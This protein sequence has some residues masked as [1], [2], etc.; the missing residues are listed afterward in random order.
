MRVR[1]AQAHLLIRTLL[2]GLWLALVMAAPCSDP[3]VAQTAGEH[4]RVLVVLSSDS[5]TATQTT[6]QRALRKTLNDGS[7]NAL[8][9]YSE[10]VGNTRAGTDYEKEFVALVQRKYEG[11]KL[12]L[13][14][15]IGQFPTRVFLRNRAELFP[16]TPIVFVAIDQ[17][18]VTDLYP[19]PGLT[20]V[21]GEIDLK[22][23]L[24]LALTLH[25]G[26][27]RVV[28]IQGTSEDDKSWAAR[29]QEDF[30]AYQSTLEFTQLTGLSTAEMQ[31][32]LSGLP[33]NT[34][35]FFV[36]NIRDNRGNTYESPDYL[37]QVSPGS[38][39]P[40]YGTTE[41]HL[42]A[43][44]VGGRLL[45]FEALGVEGA[46]VGLRVLA[47]EKPEAINPYAVPSVIMFD[48]RELQR[49][50]ISEQSLPPGSIVRFKQP[51]FWEQYKW[52][53]ISFFTAIVI[54]TLLIGWLLFTRIR[55]RQAE[56]ESLR[57][58]RVAAAEHRRLGEIVSNVPGIVW[59]S[60]IDPETKQ[61]KTTFISDHLRKMLGYTPEEWLTSPGL[62]LK[63]MPAEDREEATRVSEAVIATGKAGSTQFRWHARD[64]RTVWA[65]NYLSPIFDGGEKIVGL[66][67]VTLDITERKRSEEALRQTEEKDRAILRAIPDL[68][69]LQT[70][71]GV[72]LDYHSMNPSDLPAP[73]ELFLGKNMKEILPPDLAEDLL[74]VFERASDVGEPQSLEYELTINDQP[75]WYEARIVSSGDNILSVVRDITSRK[76]VEEALKRNEAQLTGIIESAMDAIITADENHKVLLFNSAAERIFGCTI[77]DAVGQP[78]NNF[79][80]E[81]ARLVHSEQFGAVGEGNLPESPAPMLTESTGLRRSGEQFPLEAS[82]SQIEIGGQNL[83]TVILRD[84]TERKQSLDKLRKS[85]ERF[86]KAFRANP[87][88]MSLTAASDGRYIDVNDSFLNMSGYLREELI[89]HTSLELNVWETP[90]SRARF[91][92]QLQE[93]GSVVNVETRFRTR[94]GSLRVLLSSAEQL[95]ID[96]EQCVLMASSDITERVLALQALRES[97]ERFGNM[98]ETAPVMIWI[99]D[100]A[101]NCTYVNRQWLEF[102]GRS[103]EQI[104]GNGWLAGIHPDDLERTLTIYGEAFDRRQ[105]FRVEFRMFGAD[106][107]Y[108]W[109]LSG[110]AARFSPTG[111]F[112]GYIGTALDITDRKE[113]EEAL[114]K[115]HEALMAAHQEVSRLKNQLEAENIY[116]QQ[117]LQLDQTFGEI[118]G[119]SDAI[120]YVLFK[121][122]QVAPTDATVLITGETGTGKELVARAIHSASLRKDRALI[123][124]NCAALAA[125]L[126][127][128]ELFGHEKGAFTGANA[129]KLGRF[130]LADGGTIFLDEIGELPLELQV[131]LLRVI[132]EGEFERLGGNHT[133]KVDVRI[134]AAT[135]RYLKQEVSKGAFREDL[136]YRLNVFPIT[137]PPLR[138]RKE[139]I[140]LMVEHFVNK[141]GPKFGK[142][143]T[144]VSPRTMQR[145]QSHS[146]PGNVRELVNVI[147]RATIHTQGSVL[148]LS[149]PLEDRAAPSRS[150]NLED[151]EREH[152]INTLEATGWRIE[153]QYG[154]AR[155][156]DLKP[157]TLRTRMTKLGI[158]RRRATVG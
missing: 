111:E 141:L 93:R 85:E 49:W 114:R 54:E 146:W 120:K 9:I 51:S 88:P 22:P 153:G 76:F 135:N 70:R 37:R 143:I 6:I 142:K 74:R 130:E 121:V 40:I 108:H 66:R 131:K 29:A 155:I 118:I 91:I 3:A 152:I 4:K 25:P 2:Q 102:T 101:K 1:E 86:G 90:E 140:P 112:L 64:G 129:R 24:E 61:R 87:Q 62:G 148:Q 137:V 15:T 99:S 13:I 65:E 35:V 34:I 124:V 52:Y 107:K 103:L 23:N 157:S 71:D 26:T 80:P 47:G 27:R 63:I 10:Y 119:Q 83:H 79:V 127:E 50:G 125:S 106:G 109:T 72:Y 39:A 81:W 67:G 55:R 138:E 59:E 12:D 156:L 104:L 154:A 69:F 21:W 123:R 14:F 57:L 94:N 45:S 43:G 41:A 110:G 19:A 77:S 17:R 116:L 36:S 16:G 11:K 44:I 133:L 42:G 7:A 158:Q 92:N 113:S 128:S 20:G 48:W 82:R 31:K 149:D 84:I 134:I 151:I 95:D 18:L 30:R 97:E 136:W 150:Q 73:P 144:E 58:A 96:G 68:M 78:L 117:E 8:E 75:R 98:A 145:L 147:E 122:S 89:G 115:A 33:Q 56:A 32:A 132:Q 53:A 139:D 105:D 28:M 46:K 126:I 38:A 5:F 60:L 100:Q